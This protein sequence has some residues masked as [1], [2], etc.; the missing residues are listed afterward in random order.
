MTTPGV[1][2]ADVRR[3]TA[4]VSAATARTAH[5]EYRAAGYTTIPN[6]L[7][8]FVDDK[9]QP[10]KKPKFPG[11][12]WKAAAK[13]DTALAVRDGFTDIAILLDR[14]VGLDF[15][16]REGEDEEGVWRRCQE[17]RKLYGLDGAICERSGRGYHL[18]AR[19]PAGEW[20]RRIWGAPHLVDE[21][22]CGT[23]HGH[24]LLLFVTP[25][26]HPLAKRCYERV[27]PLVRVEDLPECPVALLEQPAP[28]APAPPTD[29][30]AKPPTN[31]RGDWLTLDIV[32]LFRAEGLYL[33]AIGDG[34][35]GVKCPWESEHTSGSNGT[36][37]VVF[38]AGDGS[39]PGFQCLHAH[40]E[41]RDIRD[42]REY[43][44]ALTVDRHCAQPFRPD[45]ARSRTSIGASVPVAPSDYDLALRQQPG[46]V[47]ASPPHL[48]GFSDLEILAQPDPEFIVAGLLPQGGL[49]ELV[50]RWGA[51]KTFLLLD[52]AMHVAG[53]MDWQGRRTRRGPVLYVYAEGA[54]RT[55]V[56]AWRSA[57]RVEPEVTVGV[58][59]VPGTVNLLDSRTVAAFAADVAAGGY[60]TPPFALVVLETLSRM[61]PGGDE[62][63]PETA[64]LVVAACEQLQRLTGATVVLSHH[65]PWNPDQQ[66]PRGHTKLP[67]AA[68][69][70]YLL[71][72]KNGLLTLTCLK[73]RD[74]EAP[75]P[76]HLKLT[77]HDSGMVI[78]A[79]TGQAA[80]RDDTDARILEIA[81]SI[82]GLST[83]SLIG[84]VSGNRSEKLARVAHLVGSGALI[85]TGTDK[86]PKW[87]HLPASVP[88][89]PDGSN[90]SGTVVLRSVPALLSLGER[91]REPIQTPE[92]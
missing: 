74:G 82:P 10:G 87:H 77:P 41:G 75:A 72:N 51:G 85:N 47:G 29:R 64:G 73:M 1:S 31:G 3:T 40:C 34:K 14:V 59:F 35:H 8:L 57:H 38:E 79:G 30:I 48:R 76:T 66:R 56:A 2:P 44:G 71:D 68:D 69:A 53:G 9:G 67:D 4:R 7:E 39:G 90:G 27:G 33:R 36:D 17:A 20:K 88:S 5:R 21:V 22:R 55:R 83:N 12:S 60:G 28:Q 50:G 13:I 25:S 45:P 23:E 86:R 43:F 42:V 19:A 92:P 46:T 52:W 24:Q 11:G 37:T 89:V 81:T 58:T 84:S 6:W 49:V 32:A 62:N 91:N 63:S 78:D 16:P 54:M 70:V 80:G 26:W 15:D 65:T 18:I 61:T